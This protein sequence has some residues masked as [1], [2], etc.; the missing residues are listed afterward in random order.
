MKLSTNTDFTKLTRVAEIVSTGHG[1]APFDTVTLQHDERHLRRKVLPLTGGGSVLID[2]LEPT[3][4]GDGDR[5]VLEDGRSVEVKAAPEDLLAI[6]PRDPLHLAELCWH[7]GNRH[8]AAQIEAGRIL[9]LHDHVIEDMLA[10]L[11]AGVAHVTEPFQPLRGAYS[12][13]HDHGHGHDDHGHHHHHG[14]H[15]HGHD[16]GQG[17]PDRFGRMPGDPHYGHNH[18]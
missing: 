13:G 11:G 8:L 7:I 3:Q 12:G 6:T 1:P 10:G 2:L 9:I 4:L 17:G 18:A 15:G 16:H 14:D 5:L